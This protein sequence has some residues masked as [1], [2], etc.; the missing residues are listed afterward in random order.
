MIGLTI[1]L[2]AASVGGWYLAERGLES[3]LQRAW[4]MH[5]WDFARTSRQTADLDLQQPFDLRVG[6]P[7]FTAGGA[8][9]RIGEVTSVSEQSGQRKA[10]AVF[11]ASAP[12]ISERARV[13]YQQTPDSL[14]WVLRTMLPPEKRQQIAGELNRAFREKQEDIL[15]ALRPL[16]E[17][18][19]RDAWAEAQREL[20]VAIAR[21]RDELD[22]LGSKY[23][24]EIV[25][26]ELV[27]L[28]KASWQ[29]SAWSW[30]SNGSAGCCSARPAAA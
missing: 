10:G 11:Y 26:R 5:L 21:H 18:A 3:P 24:W 27:P 19:L 17:D 30:P 14:E 8:I 25:E 23:Q 15:R 13:T 16:V 29:P 2:L 12:P 4:V 6:D 9:R 28:V 7:I 20:P 22:R 1:W